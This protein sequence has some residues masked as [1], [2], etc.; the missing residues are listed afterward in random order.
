MPRAATQRL[1]QDLR[2]SE[3]RATALSKQNETTGA[4]AG[5][6][7]RCRRGQ[8]ARLR[9]PGGPVGGSARQPLR[10]QRDEARRA[11]AALRADV[12]QLRRERDESRADAAALREKLDDL[13]RV[14]P[15]RPAK[16]GRHSLADESS[17]EPPDERTEEPA[18][19]ARDAAQRQV[20]E[21][22]DDNAWPVVGSH[23]QHGDG[24]RG[25]VTKLG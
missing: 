6:L 12:A 5:S 4:Y 13:P 11:T 3:A 18:E 23:V 8:G 25:V 2:A 15:A 1:E 16:R 17:D 7:T 24:L 22:V 10:A 14:T 9:T 21:G 19:E 20:V